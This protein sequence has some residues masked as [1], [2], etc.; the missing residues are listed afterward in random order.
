[1]LFDANY[2]SLDFYLHIS[3]FG[4]FLVLVLWIG[5]GDNRA[6]TEL[7]FAHV[8]TKTYAYLGVLGFFKKNFANKKCPPPQPNPIFKTQYEIHFLNFFKC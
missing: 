3:G 7:G 8:N 4:M 1:M 2:S 5:R 6:V